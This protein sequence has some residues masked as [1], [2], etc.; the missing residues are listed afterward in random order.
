MKKARIFAHGL[1]GGAYQT[2]KIESFV[3]LADSSFAYGLG[4]GVERY[5]GHVG[6]RT[7]ADY[8]YTDGFHASEHNLRVTGGIAFRW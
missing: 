2:H 1:V 4:G 7:A 8:I 3:A 6:L 5:W